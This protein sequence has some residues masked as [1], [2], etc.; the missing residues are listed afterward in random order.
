MKTLILL[1]LPLAAV[2][3]TVPFGEFF[4]PTTLRIDYYHTGN[5]AEEEVT[6][7]RLLIGGAWAGNPASLIDHFGAGR[8]AVK[9]YDLA[10]NRLIY[11][12]GYDSY[13]G[14]YK[15]TDVARAGVKRTYH[16]SV[17]IPLPKRKA[18]LVFEMRDGRNLYHPKWTRVVDPGHYAIV[19]E[20]PARG[21]RVVPVVRGGDPARAVDIVV[22]A[23]GYTA[24]EESKFEKDLSRYAEI[25]FSVEPYRRNRPRFN[26][27]GIFVASAESGVDEPRQGVFRNTAFGCSFN[28][29]DSDRYL[30]TE[31]NRALRDA[32]A[33][34]PYDIIL[35]MV[36]STRYGGGGIYGTYSD[37]TSDGPMNEHLFHHE[38]A[39]AFGGLGDE[40]Y[41]S[42]VAVSEFYPQGVEPTDPN[43]TAL[44]DPAALKWKDLV[45]AGLAIPTEWGK[46]T[47]DS[48][49]A[50]QG[51]LAKER[52]ER[53]A[54]L[55]AS[56]AADSTLRALERDYGARIRAAS[57]AQVSF[58][59]NHPLRGK[60]GA[61]EGGGYRSRGIYRPTVNSIMHQFNA[62]DKQ[63]FGVNERALEQ[64]IQF[65]TR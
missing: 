19:R 34:V 46:R 35:V 26:V 63:F 1:L 8:Y 22:L 11:A 29:L 4:E 16:E 23:E 60:I 28:A 37:F 45:P 65:Y 42:D 62:S 7:D 50:V 18:L 2:A 39:H 53:T 49:G 38:F 31:G 52:S 41:S 58:M 25:L 56:G 30:M 15:T 14:E 44:L 47:F 3:Q 61:F 21:D 51:E 57:D 27:S 13:Y 5:S 54:A 33:Q 6:V 12:R 55:R 43:L 48:L 40:Y 17:L 20:K 64:M 32:A 24:A 59:A 36:N 9:V 10:T